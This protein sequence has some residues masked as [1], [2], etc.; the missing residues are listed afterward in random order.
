MYS[1]IIRLLRL[2]SRLQMP[3]SS[4]NTKLILGFMKKFAL[5]VALLSISQVANAAPAA[6]A[7]ASLSNFNFEVLSGAGVTADITSF[8][9]TPFVNVGNNQTSSSAFIE[10]FSVPFL[11]TLRK[12]LG[13]SLSITNINSN[14]GILQASS[15]TSNGYAQT[16]IS[17]WINLDYKAH[18]L[19]KFSADAYV[20]SKSNTD[21][22]AYSSTALG[23]YAYDV[24]TEELLSNPYTFFNTPFTINESIDREQRI[25]LEYFSD[26][27]TTIKFYAN[28][29]TYVD[30][31]ENVAV[32]PEPKTYAML[33]A[34][35]GLIGFA[36]HQ[37]KI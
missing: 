5:G 36:V 19:V 32:I 25:S 9:I 18:S 31:N 28:L 16:D 35:L 8:S 34:G 4:H 30:A 12:N 23:L 7:S 26:V 22:T 17:A 13:S 15:Q 29:N 1:Q 11:H 33:L 10:F 24:L 2:L 20:F 27:D 3:I 21:G 6:Q 14:D 37:R